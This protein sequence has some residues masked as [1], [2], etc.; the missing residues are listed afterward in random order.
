M[1]VANWH[2]PEAELSA[3]SLRLQQLLIDAIK[4]LQ[5]SCPSVKLELWI[6][7]LWWKHEAEH[8][9]NAVKYWVSYLCNDTCAIKHQRKSSV[10]A[11]IRKRELHFIHNLCKGQEKA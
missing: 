6:C 9:R 2:I 7:T 3:G 11:G 1:D 10:S 8:G 4:P 5:P